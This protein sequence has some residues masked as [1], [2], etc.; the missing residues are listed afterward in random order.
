LPK[1]KRTEEKYLQDFGGEMPEKKKK[2][3]G[4]YRHRYE[5]NIKVDLQVFGRG[6]WTGL[7]WLRI[8][9]GGGLL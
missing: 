6:A 2:P 3:L 1:Y 9:T 7:I 5:A 8:G 4:R